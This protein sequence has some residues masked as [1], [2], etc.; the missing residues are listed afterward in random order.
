MEITKGVSE[1][2]FFSHLLVFTGNTD[3]S[4]NLCVGLYPLSIVV[5]II[6]RFISFAM[7]HKVS[8]Y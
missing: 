3:A 7:L 5:F 2:I 4:W 1:S 8:F 6:N